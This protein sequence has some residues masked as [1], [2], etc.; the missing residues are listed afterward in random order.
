MMHEHIY[1]LNVTVERFMPELGTPKAFY[2]CACGSE[3]SS[4]EGLAVI[5]AAQQERALDGRNRGAKSK[6]LNGKGGYKAA[7]Q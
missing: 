1:S 5:N 4:D 2:K 3:L 7:R 6:P